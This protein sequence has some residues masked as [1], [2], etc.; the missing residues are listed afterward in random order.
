M[1]VLEPAA[2]EA[3]AHDV[4]A[5]LPAMR[6]FSR[7]VE[8]AATVALLLV[9]AF[10]RMARLSMVQYRYDD[11][12]L[13][14]IVTAM[15][16]TGRL[17]LHGLTSTI[18]L[19]NGPFQAYLLAPLAWL[20]ANPPMLTLGVMFLNLLA[21]A[22][23]YGFARDFFGRRV[24][25]LAL[26]LVA[27][28]P[29]ATVL[30]RRLLGNDMVAPFA[31]LALWMLARWLFR[32]DGK[33]AVIAAVALAVGGQ[34]YVLGLELLAPAAVALLLAGRRVWS[35]ALL[36]AAVVFAALIGP[37]VWT[38][39]LP[40]GA[41]LFYIESQPAGP[42]HWDFSAI[43][44]ALQL[45]GNAGYQAYAAQAGAHLD[46]TRGLLGALGLTAEG[47]YALGL[48][49]GAWT[50]L[51]GPG[52]LRG[53][54]RCLHLL[55]LTAFIVPVALLFR[56]T[57]AAPVRLLYLVSTFPLPY[58]YGAFALDRLWAWAGRLP[59]LPRVGW[60][61]LLAGGVTAIVGLNLV[62]GGVFLQVIGEYWSHGD[63]GIPWRLNY[64]AGQTAV[65]LQRQLGAERILVLDDANDYNQVAWAMAERGD[66]VAD[67]DDRRLLVLP[68]APTVYLAPNDQW[69]Q[70]Q[71]QRAYGQYLVHQERLPGEGDVLRYYMLPSLPTAPLPPGAT[72]L[73]WTAGSLLRIDGV[74]APARA[75]PGQPFDVTVAMTVLRQPQPDAPDYSV[76]VHVLGAD[77]AALAKSD[78]LTFSTRAWRPGDHILQRF[79][80]TLPT[81]APPGLHTL[82]LGV[83]H[84]DPPGNTVHPLDLRDAAGRALGASG[85]LAGPTT[86]PPPPGPPQHSLAVAF[87]DGVALDGYDL[88]SNPGALIV[89][90]H[91]RATATP[92]ASYTAFVHL[93][94]ASGKL[95]A[96]HDGPPLAG[97]YPTSAWQAGDQLADT[98][99]IPLPANL[100]AG[101]YHLAIG[102]YNSKTLQRL[103]VQSGA[104]EAV[105]MLQG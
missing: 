28:S 58:L 10:L 13:Y 31:V 8:L 65:A 52:S 81:N 50:V 12:A 67:F 53:E 9:A 80:L 47:L 6:A 102:L 86:T 62:L 63:Y 45:A 56:P 82:A 76:F 94:D 103:A 84:A 4:S 21:V 98:Y 79:T 15:A 43:G 35:R 22:L 16:Q 48:V 104:P 40:Q 3:P 61:T 49:I 92:S 33:A 99:V 95:L 101:T 17:P 34:V 64:D 18:A 37:Y 30:S 87:A 105:V 69:A 78:Q 24:G 91:W 88:R 83:Y 14:K 70:A 1:K 72:R 38:Q 60:Q 59:R 46:A 5:P 2:A 97:R 19:A 32:R 11:D 44:L 93:L 20:G 85:A 55:L 71:L 54:R 96:Q 90:L 57:A 77:S 23:V 25:L 7:H 39:V 26:L 27:V 73:D 42:A 100:P 51:R 68:G 29:W 75:Q 36:A 41:R 66:T 89:T 74:A